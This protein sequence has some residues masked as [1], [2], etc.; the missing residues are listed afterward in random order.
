MNVSASRSNVA[1]SRTNHDVL[2]SLCSINRKSEQSGIPLGVVKLH[3]VGDKSEEQVARQL[4]ITQRDVNQFCNNLCNELNCLPQSETLQEQAIVRIWKKSQ[5]PPPTVHPWMKLGMLAF[6]IFAGCRLFHSSPRHSLVVHGDTPELGG[7]GPP[8]AEAFSDRPSGKENQQEA[9]PSGDLEANDETNEVV[10]ATVEGRQTEAWTFPNAL[11]RSF[12]F[13][14]KIEW[15]GIPGLGSYSRSMV[16][17]GDTPELGGNGPPNAEAFSDRPSGKENQQEAEPS[18][19]LEANDETKAVV[20]SSHT[21]GTSSKM[22]LESG[23]GPSGKENQA[24]EAEPSGDLEANDEAKATVESR[25]AEATKNDRKGTKIKD[26]NNFRR[27]PSSSGN[28]EVNDETK[29]T[30]EAAAESSRTE[31]TKNDRKGT[32]IKDINFRSVQL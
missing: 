31:A 16:V 18:G 24:Q 11:Y 3:M 7:N 21:E 1:L 29:A 27:A 23:G 32:K 6:L 5:Q 30:V 22:N 13:S 28:S 2:K 20:E 9:E 8:N 26:I 25:H 14:L 19:D 4:G 10:E 12:H 17:H 15:E